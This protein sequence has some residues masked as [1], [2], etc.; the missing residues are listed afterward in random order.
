MLVTLL[1]LESEERLIKDQVDT[2]VKSH[3][4]VIYEYECIGYLQHARCY[5]GYWGQ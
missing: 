1:N 5:I 2:H 4:Y 3:T